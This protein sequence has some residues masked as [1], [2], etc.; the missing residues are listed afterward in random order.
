MRLCRL[1]NSPAMSLRGLL[2]VL[3]RVAI[4]TLSLVILFSGPSL[5]GQTSSGSIVGTAKDASG[6]VLPG[7]TITVTNVGTTFSREVSTNPSGDFAALNV[8]PGTYTVTAKLQGFKTWTRTGIDVR[9]NQV[10]TVDIP[11]E[12]GAVT[13]SVEVTGS[14]PLLQT[15][16]GTIGHVVEQR[17]IQQLPL[18]GR[19]FTQLT[20]LV[21][22]AAPASLPGG[23][24]VIGG[25]PVAVSG[26]RPDQNSYTLDG[27]Y[28]NETFFKF[29]GIRPSVDA[30]EEFNIQTNITSARYGQG[31]A[32]VDLATRSGS[33][34]IHGS[35]F[36]FL[37]NNALDANDFFRNASNVDR[38]VFRQNQFGGT[39]GGPVYLPKVYN[40]R[41]RSF[42]FF[43]YEGLRN[44]QGGSGLAT[45]PTSAML[46]LTGTG[47]ADL[48]TDTAGKPI[49]QIYNPF[50]TCGFNG[51]P[52][53]AIDANGN[54][55]LTRQ[56]FPGNQVPVSM[57][58]P[59]SAVWIQELYAANPPNR[60][61]P[62]LSDNL[63]NTK[64]T[65]LTSNQITIRGDQRITAKDTVYGRYSWSKIPLDE[66]QTLPTQVR[67][68][69]N[70][71]RN[72]TLSW[73][74]VFS[75]TTVLEVKYGY[76]RDDISFNTPYPP[77]GF[78][79]L[80]NAG[81][82]GVPPKFQGF[83]TPINLSPDGFAG[84]DLFVFHNGPD[85]NHQIILN[86]MKIHGRNTF[87]IGL[88]I[89]RTAMFHDG[90]FSNW[91]F[92]SA[93]TAD[94]Q[95][96]GSTGY[97]LASFL[98][99]L[100]STADRIIGNA[101]LNG[102][103][104]D[105][106]FYVQDDIKIGPKLT[107]DVGL[108][109]EYNEWFRFRNDTIAGYDVTN[110]QFVWAGY[111]YILG[112]PSNTRRTFTDPDWN[113]FAPRLGF[114]Y[115]YN[116]RTTIRGGYGVY[117]ARAMTWEASQN[118]GNWPYAVTQ[119]LAGLNASTPVSRFN[120]VFPSI[121]ISKVPPSATHT[122]NRHDRWPYM[123]SWNMNIQ[124]ELAQDLLL[125][126]GYVGSKGTKLSSFVSPNDPR[127]G[128]GVVGCPDLFN[129]LPVGACTGSPAHPRPHPN[130]GPF[131]SN[132]M[133]NNSRYHSLQT[134]L[135]RRF[136]NGLHLMTSYTWSHN[137]DIASTF[138]GDTP[139]DWYN[140]NAGYGNSAFDLRHNF[141]VSSLYQLPFGPGRR[142][143]NMH[144][145]V[146]KV[147]EGWDLDSIISI[148]SG[149]PYNMTINVDAANVGAR[150][151]SQH[152]S[153]VPGQN[154]NAGP[155]TT[156]EWFNVSA[157]ATC[158][159]TKV[160]GLSTPP[161][162]FGNVGRNTMTGPGFKNFDMGL[163]K[164]TRIKER[165]AIEF[166][167]EFFNTF[168]NVNF[169]NPASTIG[170]GRSDAGSIGCVV[171]QSPAR[172]IQFALKYLF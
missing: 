81:F 149:F 103:A 113:N 30:I 60:I 148:H 139:Q 9:L 3:G 163:H 132:F 50:T 26:I 120:N 123:Q 105:H 86:V 62:G 38:P 72:L 82:T 116:E 166:R 13:Q 51:N 121:D 11:L 68:R 7:V 97:S 31:G 156:T 89:K 35:A 92:T 142:Y 164:T 15:T 87:N 135:E 162:C 14:V 171:S 71:F 94:P 37:R 125:E 39:V 122:S 84:A 137:I 138:G 152:P 46:G 151:V 69:V 90:Q 93:P 127:P 161:F 167:A 96:A 55:I 29:Y 12:L 106:Q 170:K 40:G 63:I 107:V 119:T 83:D 20:L 42:F 140:R 155:K 10:T 98:L 102:L 77:P 57:I 32:H 158:N 153:L 25:Q 88:E 56:T 100:P 48:S 36:E 165:Q 27:T 118:R 146:G 6:A 4:T 78:Q 45:V 16:E 58:D 143:L 74:R 168:N 108:R 5:L 130:I 154:P 131:S 79:A 109:Y 18:N 21:P 64:S 114:A 2:R 110:D 124:R 75:P 28:N 104:T 43:D 65:V 101:A 59:V 169:C 67:H 70:G 91:A 24:F 150:A 66:P 23:F 145:P 41:D 85:R 115:R 54:P 44:S 76:A 34:D 128:P 1:F 111:N 136:T 117:Y 17:S 47:F 99:G 141:V 126:V 8:A 61:V 147:F 80:V 53:C 112:L 160:F 52:A 49:P 134:K 95:N 159:D 172:Q 157:F 73:T 133:A 33:N 22:G 19:D 129:L 144:G